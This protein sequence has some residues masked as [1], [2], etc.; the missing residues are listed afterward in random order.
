MPRSVPVIPAQSCGRRPCRGISRGG[1][2]RQETDGGAGRDRS[3]SRPAIAASPGAASA[4][5][6]RTAAAI[7][8]ATISRATI[9]AAAI[10]RAAI[11]PAARDATMEPRAPPP[12]K[13]RPPPP[14]KPPRAPPPP[15]PPRTRIGEIP[16]ESDIGAIG[17]AAAMSESMKTQRRPRRT[18]GIYWKPLF[19]PPFYFCYPPRNAPRP[20]QWIK[21]TARG[22]RRKR[23]IT[24][25]AVYAARRPAI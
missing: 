10:S 21:P 17:I 19:F 23:S 1:S 25:S 8:A 18:C 2:R 9:G 6:D 22:A 20:L 16:L 12:W 3:A 15:R 24:M 4:D 14:W 11:G 13:P 7:D 5:D